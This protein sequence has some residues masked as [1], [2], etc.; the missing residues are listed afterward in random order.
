MRNSGLCYNLDSMLKFLRN[1]R[2]QKRLF[3][4]LAIIIVPSFV[5]WGAVVD[6]GAYDR[7]TVVGRIGPEKITAGEFIKNFDELR[8]EIFLFQGNRPDEN[9]EEL[10]RA[11]WERLLMLHEAGRLGIRTSNDEVIAWLAGMDLFNRRGKFDAAFYNQFVERQFRIPPRQFEEQIRKF[12]TIQKVFAS[13]VPADEITDKDAKSFFRER[14]APRHLRYILLT[15]NSAEEPILTDEEI[16]E[17]YEAVK[18]IL[19]RPEAVNVEYLLIEKESP[20]DT[21]EVREAILRG[22]LNEAKVYGLEIK[23]TGFLSRTDAIPQIGFSEELTEAIFNL[24]QEGEQSPLVEIENGAVICRLLSKRPAEPI[25]FEEAKARLEK[26]LKEDKKKQALRQSA[27]RLRDIILEEDLDRM[28]QREELKVY[29]AT[30]F[31]RDDY[32]DNVGILERFDDQIAPLKEGDVSEPIQTET[33]YALIQIE[34][35]REDYE[36][37][38]EEKKET[39]LRE[40]RRKVQLEAYQRHMQ[41]LWQELYINPEAMQQLFGG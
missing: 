32:L 38:F 13:F 12:L 27:Q 26:S 18:H 10:Q 3:F 29:E 41:P 23:E 17:G 5:L 2:N 36:E 15:Y 14:F 22:G 28:A 34:D 4:G 1:K 11:T 8:R 6:R 39:L 7:N 9:L 31:K 35:I 40:L 37:G 19:L 25:P 24:D 21:E 30:D 20:H 33:G 16:L